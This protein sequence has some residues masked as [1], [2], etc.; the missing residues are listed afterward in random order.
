MVKKL[1]KI[2]KAGVFKYQHNHTQE[3][4]YLNQLEARWGHM[5]FIFFKLT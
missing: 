4:W 1:S 5:Q 3:A 2:L